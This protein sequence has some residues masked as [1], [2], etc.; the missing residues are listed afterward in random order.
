MAR[1]RHM[2]FAVVG[3]AVSLIGLP[4]ASYAQ[5]TELPEYAY[6]SVA[7]ISM[8]TTAQAECDGARVNEARLQRAM[9]DLVGRLAGDGLDPVASVR[10]MD[11]EAGQ[12]EIA[13]REVALR[14]RHGVAPE[15]YPALCDAIRAESKVNKDLARIVKFR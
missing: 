2:T 7:R 15:G 1:L 5:V 4:L 12:A 13:K 14:E 3:I 9:T 8:I 6:D 11:T 10:F